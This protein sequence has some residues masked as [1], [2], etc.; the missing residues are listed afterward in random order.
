M[1]TKSEEEREKINAQFRKELYQAHLD[2]VEEKRKKKE[3]Q[4]KKF[5]IK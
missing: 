1:Q 2:K 5:G 3:L 4:K